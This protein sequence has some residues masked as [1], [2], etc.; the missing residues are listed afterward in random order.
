MGLVGA[1]DVTIRS[2]PY[3]LMVMSVAI[4]CAL[5]IMPMHG[6]RIGS[7]AGA[8]RVRVEAYDGA[9]Y[10]HYESDLDWRSLPDVPHAHGVTWSRDLPR[11]EWALAGAGYWS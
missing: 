10:L 6:I 8:P 3:V 4:F 2:A 9:I 1:W 7:G 5:L 11:T